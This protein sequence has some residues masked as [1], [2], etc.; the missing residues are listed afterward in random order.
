MLALDIVFPDS[1]KLSANDYQP[2]A[3]NW[4][5]YFSLQICIFFV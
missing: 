4:A 1:Y 3:D 5:Q 2:L